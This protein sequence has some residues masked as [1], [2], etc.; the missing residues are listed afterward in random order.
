[1]SPDPVEE[2]LAGRPPALP[3]PLV[4][5]PDPEPSV[6]DELLTGAR[7]LVTGEG[8]TEYPEMLD[9]GVHGP[10]V[11]MFSSEG[12][13]M[14]GG[15]LS[16]TDP[17][18]IAD[19]AVKTLPGATRRKDK[20][21]NP[22]I[23]AFGEEFYVN[24][25]G[26]SPVDALQLIGL[27]VEFMPA[28]KLG[29]MA[30][31]IPRRMATTGPG[32]AATSAG[33]DVAAGALGSEQGVDVGKAALVGALGAGF[34]LAAPLVARLW[35]AFK[36]NPR[37]I[38]PATGTLTKEGKRA[39]K[40]AGVKEE[41]LAAFMAENERLAA[42]YAAEAVRPTQGKYGG[43]HAEGREF[44]VE[45]TAGQAEYAGSVARGEVP[46]TKLIRMEEAMAG[47]RFGEG[48]EQA[49][50]GKRASQREQVEKAGGGVQ[51]ELAGGARR[52]ET[53]AEAGEIVGPGIQSRAAAQEARVA[54]AYEAA[55]ARDMRFTAE[56]LGSMFRAVRQGLRDAGVVI[57]NKA[58]TTKLYPA[59]AR[60][61][62]NIVKLSREVAKRK[63]FPQITRQSLKAFELARRRINATIGAAKT[64]ADKRGAV[65]IKR[66]FDDWLDGAVD[67]ALFMGDADA[68]ALL[69]KARGTR[70][71]YGRVFEGKDEAGQII[72]KILEREP[73][74]E[75][76]INYILGKVA[77]GSRD[78]SAKVLGRLKEMFGADSPE[79]ASLREA[80]WLRLF[81]GRKGEVVSPRVFDSNFR[82][83]MN[84][85]PTMMRELFTRAEI[86]KMRRFGTAALRTLTP[87]D[88][89]NYS[90]TAD[91]L[92][93]W[94]RLI[95]GRLGTR[96]T[97]S[98]DPMQAA[99]L[100]A[101][102]RSPNFFAGRRARELI[103]PQ[104]RAETAP[105]FVAGAGVA[106]QE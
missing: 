30:S 28:A 39:A 37:F 54:S 3:P 12:M 24:S 20:F 93:H 88:L 84:E 99:G 34:E 97:F 91:A 55:G 45:Y 11:P 76:T 5:P 90:R 33:L 46:A 67:D 59:T 100:H 19:I 60:A 32:F 43:V 73:T 105:P 22:I 81:K 16:T 103:S 62:D 79:W 78:A 47:G 31:T 77:L 50:R 53:P 83:V 25:P 80:G 36:G 21:G 87:D 94:F 29:S 57:E 89:V 41:E 38:D 8:R 75:Q 92:A 9:L 51:D 101:I 42:E 18:A 7:S 56:S 85:A 40:A 17:E 63:K 106:G 86:N 61:F 15:Y 58:V 27:L 74:A 68:L 10:K 52:I 102:A 66:H 2:L 1:M 44:G 13:R 48:A 35:Q 69:K 96:A 49:I 72:V 26:F 70:A 82:R 23:K 71:E 14:L 64:P 65:L 6:V 95:I 104:P 98:G 4:S